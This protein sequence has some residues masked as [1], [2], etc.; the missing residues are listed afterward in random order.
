MTLFSKKSRLRRAHIALWRYSWIIT[1][2]CSIFFFYWIL[3]T[4]DRYM[5]FCVKY[6][7]VPY[8]TDLRTIGQENFSHMLRTLRLKFTTESKLVEK[9]EG[10]ESIHLFVSKTNLRKLNASL[11]HSGYKYVKGGLWDGGK[12]KKAKIKYRGD[13]LPHWGYFKKSM[14]IKLGKNSLF[15][16]MK[17]FNLIRPKFSM[18]LNN[19]LAYQLAEKL[20]LIAPRTALT[21]VFING[22]YAGVYIMVEQI[23]ENILRNRLL[24]PGDLY[25]GEMMGKDRF[26]GI[27]SHVFK[28]KGVWEKKTVNNGFDK[29]A[30]PPIEKLLNLI[31]GPQNEHAHRK[32]IDLLDMAA[33]GKFS[34]FQTLVQSFHYKNT[35]NWRLYYDSSRQKLLPIVWDPVGWS[36]VDNQD[37][38]FQLKIISSELHKMLFQNDDFMKARQ[39]ALTSFF[40]EHSDH[41]FLEF[42]DKTVR[43]MKRALSVDPN[44]VFDEDE[45][46][47]MMDLL[48]QKIPTYF[49]RIEKSA[50]EKQQISGTKKTLNHTLYSMLSR[51]K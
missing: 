25:V 24:M 20:G 10:L 41:H 26:S 18:Q 1:L 16:K 35:H 6:N 51:I 15:K 46:T 27:S 23:D 22:N 8:A 19:Y 21:Q 9:N 30:P 3:S 36:H 39:K 17:T 43:V 45:T 44:L 33:W 32:L 2:P 12:I 5:Q 29:S 13:F 49:Q 28:H 48:L 7:T 38:N 34:A 50:Q 47:L 11:P 42:A 14:R 31:N 4:T 40:N 37:S